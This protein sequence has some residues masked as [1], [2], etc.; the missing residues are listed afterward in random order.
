MIESGD[1]LKTWRLEN[2]PEQLATETTKAVPIFD[3]DKKFLTYQ[4]PVNNGKGTVEI[5]DHG[6]CDIIY[7][8]VPCL[9]IRLNQNHYTII[10]GEEMSWISPYQFQL[11]M[12]LE[13]IQNYIDQY[14]ENDQKKDD[15]LHQIV[16]NII[17]RQP[18]FMTYEDLKEFFHWKSGDRNIGNIS[19]NSPN[20]IQIITKEAF[21]QIEQNHNINEILAKER[22]RI[23]VLTLLN[24]IAWPTASAILHFVFTDSYPVI[25]F[26][27]LRSVGI[28]SFNENKTDRF[29]NF[30][31]WWGYTQ[32]CRMLARNFN[33]CMRN[34]DKA[35]W[36]FGF[37][38]S[39]E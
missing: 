29:C 17:H 32:Y 9:A 5:V 37:P 30:T 27:A 8:N 21:S 25:D 14:P 33:I 11:Q 28:L 6:N 3:H 39:R 22:F 35:L 26:R 12:P 1:K 24:G 34:L 18:K 20:Y 16:E 4:G 10:E 36:T 15:N 31:F 38:L 2:P 23:E 13:Q 19:K 7:S